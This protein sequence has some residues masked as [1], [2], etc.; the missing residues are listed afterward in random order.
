MNHYLLIDVGGSSVK[1][2]VTDDELN[3]TEKGKYPLAMKSPKEN[4]YA[5]MNHIH[6]MIST[7]VQ[8]IAISM[9]G[10][11]DEKAGINIAS[12]MLN[13]RNVPVAQVVK[14]LTGVPVSVINDGY[15]AGMAELGFGNMRGIDNGIVM[16]LGTGIGGA[17]IIN[18]SLHTGKRHAAANLSF[19][20]TDINNPA[21]P[22]TMTTN[23]S[24]IQG[25]KNAIEKTSGLKNI[26]GLK[27]FELIKEGN[28]EV[29]KGI[30]LFCDHLAFQ[31]YNLESVLDMDRVLI[32]GGISNE[33]SFITYVQE[34]VD[35]RWA[36]AAV[37]FNKPEIMNCKYSSDANLIGAFYN[38]QL[39]HN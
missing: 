21:D 5:A 18:G 10:I 34:A 2:A 28:E 8:G 11:I 32:G 19:L 6:N 29:K 26:D 20:Y 9:P 25:L 15:A 39:N 12:S 23:Y 37:P 24:G 38:W 13:D 17:M 14:E 7:E 4:F 36:S 33:P 22:G 3:L 30:E 35:R 27:A 1:F 31:I 16:V